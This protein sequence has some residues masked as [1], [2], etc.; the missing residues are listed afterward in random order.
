MSKFRLGRVYTIIGDGELTNEMVNLSVSRKKEEM[1]S[2]T[3]GG[4]LKYIVEFLEP[5]PTAV[6]NFEWYS[7]DEINS[8]WEA[9]A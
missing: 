7:I 3:V 9:L 2:K 5:A 1:I 6:S 8:V 4:V